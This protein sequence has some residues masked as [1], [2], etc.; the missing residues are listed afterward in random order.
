[1][2]V[3]DPGTRAALTAVPR[4]PGREN[5]PTSHEQAAAGLAGDYEAGDETARLQIAAICEE[6]G[7]LAALLVL[8]L[9][10]ALRP[11]FVRAMQAAI[12]AAE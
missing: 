8:A 4:H 10:E 1:V 3:R 6:Q 2:T 11:E 5:A 7:I 9:P 12:L